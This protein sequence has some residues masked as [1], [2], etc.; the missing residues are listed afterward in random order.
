MKL[1]SSPTL[2]NSLFTINATRKK[3]HVAAIRK[4]PDNLFIVKN[5]SLLYQ[6]VPRKV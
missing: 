1:L 4:Q 6:N 3:K 5:P 2:Q